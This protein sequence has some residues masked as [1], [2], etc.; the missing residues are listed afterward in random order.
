MVGF[1]NINIAAPLSDCFRRLCCRDYRL[2]PFIK[3]SELY[4]YS[5]WQYF[6]VENEDYQSL[7]YQAVHS[8]MV[9][10]WASKVFPNEAKVQYR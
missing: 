6:F 9:S 7:V 3:L 5:S 1:I 8:R 4:G 2:K 10:C